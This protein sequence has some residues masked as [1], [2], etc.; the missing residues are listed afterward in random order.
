M[1]IV[2]TKKGIV[3]CTSDSRTH[4]MQTL[5][6]GI[7]GAIKILDKEVLELDNAHF[8]IK[9]IKNSKLIEYKDDDRITIN[10]KK[11]CIKLLNYFKNNPDQLSEKYPIISI[12]IKVWKFFNEGNNCSDYIE[13]YPDRLEVSCQDWYDEDKRSAFHENIEELLGS[14][15]AVAIDENLISLHICITE[16]CKANCKT[17]YLDRGLQRELQKEDWVNLPQAEQFAI[18]GGE[19]AEYPLI[20]ELIDYI[21]KDRN[22]YI[23]ITT[24]GQKIINFGE[25]FPDKIAVSIDGLIQKEHDRTHNTNLKTAEKAAEFYKSI[26][27]D[28]CINHILHK[29]NID[30]VKNFTDLWVDKRGCEVNLIIFIGEDDLKPTFKQ[31][32]KF[33]TYFDNVNDKRIL[34]DSCMTG[35]L[36][37]LDS[38]G[39]N[40]L[41]QQGLYSKYYGFGAINP[42]SHSATPYPHCRIMEDYFKY[43]FE[44]LRPIV[45]IYDK[46]GTSGAHE[47]AFKV[48]HKGKIRHNIDR[49]LR[50]DSIYIIK[51]NEEQTIEDEHY[52]VFFKDKL[53]YWLTIVNE[54]I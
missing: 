14:D 4:Y 10:D 20:V 31:L 42:C 12:S 53:P 1:K 51:D 32:C 54:K 21:K 16:K 47:W 11:N 28:V 13:V 36:N 38:S 8:Y 45:F 49:P 27:I 30:N 46:D 2:I 50:E 3:D 22:G 33:K 7:D 17:C 26:G 25:Y 6:D 52:I 18:G 41:C 23:A 48:G 5:Y 15:Y 19:P 44:T 39:K 43:F 24:N 9:N 37:I 29:E 34:I 40:Y 35:L